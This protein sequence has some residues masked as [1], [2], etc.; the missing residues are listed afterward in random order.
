MA[1][2]DFLFRMGSGVLVSLTGSISAPA[3]L[4]LLNLP[5]LC[6][7][8]VVRVLQIGR[9]RLSTQRKY[10]MYA[11]PVKP[12]CPPR[13]SNPNQPQPI[14]AEYAQSLLRMLTGGNE[15][16]FADSSLVSIPNGQQLYT[17]YSLH[18]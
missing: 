4:A 9:G 12:N 3:L 6:A 8:W 1:R 14:S 10:A 16:L 15:S 13:V 17:R 2:H 7:Q 18:N 11:S 5:V